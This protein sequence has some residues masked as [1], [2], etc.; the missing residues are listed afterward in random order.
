MAPE[1]E[2]GRRS[3]PR[4]V[5]P[6]TASGGPARTGCA[7]GSVLGLPV[8]LQLCPASRRPLRVLAARGPSPAS[9]S[10]VCSPSSRRLS[11]HLPGESLG[12]LFFCP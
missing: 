2:G 7:G 1:G 8:S 9:R 5:R 6:G 10:W 4:G 3:G 12:S 11:R